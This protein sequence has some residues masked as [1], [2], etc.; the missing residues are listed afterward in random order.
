MGLGRPCLLPGFARALS[1]ALWRREP[2]ASGVPA[3]DLPEPLGRE[4]QQQF[5]VHK[6]LQSTVYRHKDPDCVLVS[7][8]ETTTDGATSEVSF[9]K[10]RFVP[11]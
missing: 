10:G 9:Q 1:Q 3:K 2:R 4:T 8:W 5:F 7:G 11:Q 6:K